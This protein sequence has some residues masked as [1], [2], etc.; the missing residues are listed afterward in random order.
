M[1]K[2][3]IIHGYQGS[4]NGGWR[5]WLM[6]ELAKLDVYACALSMPKPQEPLLSEWVEEIARHVKENQNDEI[7][8]VGHSLGVPAI[9]HYIE[10]TTVTNVMGSILVSGP[11]E[12]VNNRN[13]EEFLSSPFD[14]STIKNKVKNFVIIHGDN[15][16]NVPFSHAEILSKELGGELIKIENGRHLNGS[17]GW[18]KLPQCLDALVKM[19]NNA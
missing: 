10:N 14:F 6:E 1:K 15:D 9:L 13:I 19:I 5:P 7:Y 18:V 17:S 8:L 16:Q 12:M 4:P 3:F 2:V 11:V